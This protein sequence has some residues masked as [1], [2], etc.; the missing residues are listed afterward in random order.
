MCAARQ[1]LEI[2]G[3]AGDTF[4]L[5]PYILN[6]DGSTSSILATL[7]VYS[8]SDAG[9]ATVSS[10]GVVT[11]HGSSSF[12]AAATG[13]ALISVVDNTHLRD[14]ILD[15]E[16]RP[17]RITYKHLSKGC[18]VI[19]VYDPNCSV[20]AL[21]PFNGNYGVL[22]HTP[23]P[24]KYVR[25]AFTALIGGFSAV[26]INST[27]STTGN[28][29][30]YAAWA[31]P[32]A[33]WN[34]G[35]VGDTYS[36]AAAIDQFNRGGG[37]LFWSTATDLCHGNI[38]Y[39]IFTDT[40]RQQALSTMFND[41]Y[42][43][44]LEDE[45]CDEMS[46]NWTSMMR[47]R[48]D[49]GS[50]QD[51]LGNSTISGHTAGLVSIVVTGCPSTPCQGTGTVNMMA[52]PLWVWSGG[53]AIQIAG[54][55]TYKLN[56]PYRSAYPP[57]Y[58]YD[59]PLGM[60]VPS[61]QITTFDVVNGTYNASTDPSMM[62][63]TNNQGGD[64]GTWFVSA[65]GA[66]V[67]TGPNGG[68][69]GYGWTD[70]PTQLVC[71]SNVCTVSWTSHPLTN[72][73][74][75]KLAGF[76]TSGLPWANG[77]YR[78]DVVN[79]NSF[80]IRVASVANGTY[81]SGTDPGGYMDAM[82]NFPQTW[83]SDMFTSYF[84]GNKAPLAGSLQGG[85]NAGM[86]SYASWQ[87]TTSLTDFVAQNA[88]PLGPFDRYGQYAMAY[89]NEF[90]QGGLNP[91]PD[92][93]LPANLLSDTK[94]FLY[95]SEMAGQTCDKFVITYDCRTDQ[96]PGDLIDFE[97]EFSG[98]T[99]ISNIVP[100]IMINGVGSKAYQYSGDIGSSRMPPNV[101]SSGS[102]FWQSAPTET[103]VYPDQWLAL[104]SANLAVQHEDKYLLQPLLSSPDENVGP[105]PWPYIQ[106][107]CQ[108]HTSSYGN[109]MLCVNLSEE[110]QTV[111]FDYSLINPG[112]AGGPMRR[113][114]LSAFGDTL[115]PLSPSTTS[116]TLT[117]EYAQAILV[118]SQTAGAADDLTTINVPLA[119]PYGAAKA[120]LE[121][122]YYL[123]DQV[124]QT[125]DC[126]T[127]ACPPI[128]V[129]LHNLDVYTRK[130]FTKSDGTPVVAGDLERLAAK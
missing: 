124:F 103:D 112:G 127:G 83:V 7:P 79:A 58:A 31:S 63:T 106:I 49:M 23:F 16:V 14:T 125:V 118:I 90:R 6:C 110:Q 4:S 51:G 119:L 30:S 36:K 21:A 78:A 86:Y 40:W 17:D 35:F 122:H 59:N 8:T 53:V 100:W 69:Q 15:V 50:A 104:V 71:L 115:T 64:Y 42:P 129:N 84:T 88:S 1:V 126:G 46:Q 56:G 111:T 47:P 85:Y 60:Y 24:I 95:Q 43:M 74:T 75:V 27:E 123:T 81:N 102:R 22:T 37:M 107:E 80:T 20:V 130:R 11:L 68:G 82:G 5:A 45:H 96:T 48:G 26:T 66:A 28:A 65:T 29:G 87:G 32:S 41:L 62:I 121:I 3:I 2:V 93:S 57:T 33:H 12:N 77:Y 67:T 72:G 128:K 39:H 73:Q 9:L 117:L 44:T 13:H 25:P 108:S 109:A 34:S 52:W 18:G 54:A 120:A 10:S 38:A 98:G 92:G 19:S 113:W 70:G 114:N 97:P 76:T 101:T 55:T 89:R 91:F 94:P 61:F 116:E 105:G 99:F